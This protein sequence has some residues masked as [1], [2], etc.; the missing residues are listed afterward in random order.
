MRGSVKNVV[1]D[2]GFGFIE[3]TKGPDVFFHFSDLQEPLEF[4]EKLIRRRISFD[5]QETGK[6]LRATNIR[7]DDGTDEPTNHE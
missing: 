4:N 2:R 1:Q 3:Q 5:V 7:P 6:G